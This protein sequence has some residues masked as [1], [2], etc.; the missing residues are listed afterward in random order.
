MPGIIPEQDSGALVIRD[1]G[2]TCIAQP[3]VI[4]GY[5]PGAD[6]TSSCQIRALPSDCTARIT[7][8]QINAFQ[9]ELLSFA[10][11]LDPD[12][13]WDCDELNNLCTNFTAWWEENE[14]HGDGVTITVNGGPQSSPN[15]FS[16]IPD[17]VANAICADESAAQ[18]LAGCVL[19]GDANNQ[20]VI[21]SDGLIFTPP[22]QDLDGDEI[23]D[24]IC[25]DTSARQTLATCVLSGDAGN[26]TTTGS[27]G[28]IFTPAG[29]NLSPD[30]I[31]DMVCGD[32][33]ARETL[34][35][36]LISGQDFNAIVP[37]DDN[38]LYSRNGTIVGTAEVIAPDYVGPSP[39]GPVLVHQEDWFIPNPYPFTINVLCIAKVH[40]RI[41]ENDLNDAGY[42]FL[43]DWIQND[44]GVGGD[45]TQ[46]HWN[47]S[48]LMPNGPECVFDNAQTFMRIVTVGAG[49]RTMQ[50][51]FELDSVNGIP[52]DI[53]ITN[54][55][56]VFQ[57]YGVYSRSINGSNP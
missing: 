30:D 1:M 33:S 28:L 36:C 15:R 5:C 4:N 39:A 45:F 11:C 34:A 21:G 42:S 51:R 25:G 27:D 38:L 16:I 43:A 31:A 24:L 44:Y 6:F 29:Q 46:W 55:S 9:S 10:E 49:G 40:M 52:A 3:L 26:Q 18:T 2:G 12:G 50:A 41:M 8:A 35:Q 19:S 23:A 17:G 56:I 13:N 54:N 53:E 14:P 7:P 57:W 20:S 22:G 47:Q 48:R 37:G 32:V